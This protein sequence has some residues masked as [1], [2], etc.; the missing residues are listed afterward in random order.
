M[1]WFLPFDPM[2][3]D[4]GIGFVCSIL[5]VLPHNA[6]IKL[7]PA[8]SVAGSLSINRMETGW[9]SF[10]PMFAELTFALLSLVF[11]SVLSEVCA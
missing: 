8:N 10:M 7:M 9:I 11:C 2:E 3:E 6:T 1:H 4:C 5:G